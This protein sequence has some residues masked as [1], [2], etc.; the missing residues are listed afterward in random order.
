MRI[1]LADD[2]ALVLHGLR[3]LLET[4]GG[5]EVVIEAQ[6][7]DALLTASAPAGG[8]DCERHSHVA[9]FRHRRGARAA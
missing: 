7:G 3:V 1:A 2:Q 9:T 8:R 5:I 4:F 6:D